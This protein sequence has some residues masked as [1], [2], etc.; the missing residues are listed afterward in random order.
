M[1]PPVTASPSL[2]ATA[3]AAPPVSMD[4]SMVVRPSVT[5]SM[6]TFSPGRTRRRSP[7]RNSDTGISDWPA[8]RTTRAVVARRPISAL[9]ASL[10]V[11]LARVS[12]VAE[13]QEGEDHHRG[14]QVRGDRRPEKTRGRRSPA[15][16]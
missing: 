16:N 7:T 9:I 14:V 2:R 13:L 15:P 8:E 12:G 10:V 3:S 1:V 11:R 5:P 4:S 6:G